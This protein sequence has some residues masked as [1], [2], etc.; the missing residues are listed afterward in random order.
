MKNLCVLSD[1]QFQ[2]SG[3][4]SS[5]MMCTGFNLGIN[6]F[7]SLGP[8]A[9]KFWGPQKNILRSPHIGPIKKKN[10]FL[11]FTHFRSTGMGFAIA[12]I[13]KISFA[14]IGKV[15]DRIEEF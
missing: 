5:H 14:N 7:E 13:F 8:Q 4:S 2:V 10:D 1:E 15:T 6:N 11:L 3:L 12:R 9:F